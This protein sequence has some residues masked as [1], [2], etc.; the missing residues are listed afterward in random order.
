MKYEKLYKKSP[1][2]FQNLI[3]SIYNYRAYRKRYGGKYK[4]Y[5]AK[6]RRNASLSYEELLD[7]Q[8]ERYANFINYAINNSK[9]YKELYKDI[10]NPEAIENIEKLPIV[11]KEM[12]HKYAKDIYT[13][14]KEQ[15]NVA[16]TGGT[17]GKSLEVVFIKD[18]RQERFAM[19]DTFRSK[20]GYKLGKKTAWFSGKNIVTSKDIIKN[21][22][23]K[24]DIFYKV[25]YYSTFHVQ[26]KNIR[27]YLDNLMVF[28]P[29]YIVGFPSSLLDI[30][31]YGLQKGIDFPEDTVKAIFPTAETIDEHARS[32]LESFFK[33]KLYD[34]YASSEGAP[35]I[36]ECEK[37]NLHF[38][39]QSG[40]FE[41]LNENNNYSQSGRLIVTAFATQGTPLI[42]YDIG[43]A[44]I[45]S[46]RTCTCGNNNPLVDKI[47]GRENDYIFSEEIGKI[48]LGNLS[49]A[50]KDVDGVVKF[51][52]IQNEIDRIKVL[53]MKDIETY[54]D[55]SEQS[56]I[57]NLRARVGSKII[58]DIEYVADIPHESS[59]K[60]RLIKNNIKNKSF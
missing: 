6:F 43:D 14:P 48:N 60:Y 42:R 50:L 26:H 25:R 53:V 32:I 47:L 27:H 56:F 29:E 5:L 12:I 18:N 20:Y 54:D 2:F 45:K 31:A 58:I 1:V 23:W 13:I 7:I 34:Q 59:G 15:G 38:E 11:N 51:Q 37:G 46:D 19:L 55:H 49:N 22:F 10:K 30:A 8:K 39:L 41:V 33:T 4:D 16:K 28:K 3:I 52:V 40:V 36:I 24:T 44:I 35:F 17:T 21:R 57:S 9:F